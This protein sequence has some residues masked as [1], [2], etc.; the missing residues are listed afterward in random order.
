MTLFSADTLLDREP[1]RALFCLYAVSIVDIQAEMRK[2]VWRTAPVR[3]LHSF[4]GRL[5]SVGLVWL[6]L[7]GSLSVYLM[8]LFRLS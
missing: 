7:A 3:R 6:G 4:C 5:L 2:G 1:R 8:R